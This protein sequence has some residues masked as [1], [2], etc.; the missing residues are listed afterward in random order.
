MVMILR[1]LI[2]ILLNVDAAWASEVG[3]L[4]KRKEYKKIAARY[5]KPEKHKAL[6]TKEMIMLSHSLRMLKRYREDTRIIAKIIKKDHQS[7]HVKI[8]KHIANK[9][10]LDSEDYPKSLPVLYWYLF[11]DY[12][13]ILLSYDKLTPQIEKDKIFFNTFRNILSELEFREGKVERLNDKV[14]SHLQHLENKVYRLSASWN[15]QYVSWQHSATLT[16]ASTNSKTSLIL[17]NQGYC[18]GGDI[19]VENGFY[20]FNMDG[21]LLVGSGGV[22]AYGDSNITYEQNVPAFGLKIGPTASMIVSSSKSRIGIGLPLIY[23]SQK[24]TQPNDTDYKV[25]EESPLAMLATINSR[26][27]FD[28]WYLRIEFG[29]YF[30]K[31]ESFWGLGFGRQ[32]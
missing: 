3:T 26:W 31:Q 11:N 14:V 19:G 24:L 27:Q 4:F 9:E 2:L 7:N 13:Q 17:T 16:R 21:C 32:F 23:T 22:S 5:I 12:A 25:E 29:Q 15:L 6:T 10:T 8:R 18:L 28:R 30:A 20:H 1:F